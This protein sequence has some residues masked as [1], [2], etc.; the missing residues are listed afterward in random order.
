MKRKNKPSLIKKFLKTLP[1]IM[2]VVAV[3]YLGVL[4]KDINIPT[5][6]PVSDIQVSGELNFIDKNEIELLVKEN[7]SGGYFAVNLSDIRELLMQNHG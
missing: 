4:I 5:V 6:L 7:I 1:V 2:G 3:I